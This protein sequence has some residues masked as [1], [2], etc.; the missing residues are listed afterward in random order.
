MKETENCAGRPLSENEGI[1]TAYFLMVL[2]LV[3]NVSMALMNAEM[4]WLSAQLSLQR[5]ADYQR[6]EAVMLDEIKCALLRGELSDGSY[7]R[8]G[9]R[10]EVAV[11]EDEIAAELFEPVRESA[12][13]S[14]DPETR[15]V[16]ELEAERPLEGEEP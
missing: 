6:A 1:V 12:V 5:A 2:M 13:I 16:M 3:S 9:V 11:S 8:D 14:Y 10:Y 15:M 4:G 7:E